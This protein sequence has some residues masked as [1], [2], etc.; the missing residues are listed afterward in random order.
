MKTNDRN[1][2]IIALLCAMIFILLC[3]VMLDFAKERNSKNEEQ[4]IEAPRFLSKVQPV[5]YTNERG[6]CFT[7]ALPG[8]G[9]W[10][11]A[12]RTNV[13]VEQIICLNP[14]VQVRKNYMLYENEEII[15]G[16]EKR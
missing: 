16:Y 7:R 14:K 1:R 13:N 5:Y 3:F 9:V 2:L 4:K 8:E 12:R 10:A 6:E 15:L 11:I